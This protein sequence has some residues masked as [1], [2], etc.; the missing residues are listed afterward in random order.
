MNSPSS[1]TMA[2]PNFERLAGGFAVV[3]EEISKTPN[4]PVINEGQAILAS[5]DRL[6]QEMGRQFRSL[7]DDI[8]TL[9]TDINTI[10]IDMNTVRTDM[11]TFHDGVNRQ[12]NNL[13][14][15]MRAEYDYLNIQ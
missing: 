3:A 7:K 12:L 10:R 9:R 5:I 13:D 14:I 8:T 4:V 11:N 1:A 6:Q 15:R 2:Q